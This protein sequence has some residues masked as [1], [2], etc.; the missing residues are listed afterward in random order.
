MT[1]KDEILELYRVFV[2][3]II[4][5]EQR[6]QQINSVFITFFAAGFG[7]TGAIN[8]FNWI[9]ATVPATVVS[10]I[11][12]AQVR[13]LKNLAKAK[14]H[15]I[16]QLEERLSYHPFKEEWRCFKKHRTDGKRT[17]FQ[18]E[19]SQIE[20]FV[21]LIILASCVIHIVI[22]ILSILLEL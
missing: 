9:Y 19:L 20:M 13:F 7:I 4:A 16:N 6:R 14:F 17:W 15:V 8:G 5:N 1:E 3:T 10:I 12:W 21:P 18:F 11:W 2:D 22:T